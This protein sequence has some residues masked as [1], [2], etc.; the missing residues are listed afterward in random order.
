MRQR[1]PKN[2][3][4]RIQDHS[5]Y[6]VQD[7]KSCRGQWK[8]AFCHRGPDQD[9]SDPDNSGTDNS[10]TECPGFGNP[11]AD[12]KI[13]LEIGSGKGLF[14]TQLA[15]RETDNLFIGFEGQDTVIIKAL[16]KIREDDLENIRMCRHYIHDLGSIF[17]GDELDGIYLNFIDPWPKGRHEKRRLTAPGYLDEYAAGLKCGA[18]VKLKTD[19][20]DLFKYSLESFEGHEAF[21]IAEICEDLHNSP[22]DAVN[23]QTEYEMKFANLNTKINYLCAV[24]NG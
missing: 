21:S 19:N 20:D 24:R 18:Y 3:E 7:P 15:K 13:F 8:S 22:L 16:E 12:K 10:N 17:A 6:L 2:L 1:R 11:N 23:I 9:H 5:S 14:I 4:K